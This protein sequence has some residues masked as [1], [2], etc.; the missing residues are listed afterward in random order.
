MY[1]QLYDNLDTILSEKQHG[2]RKGFSLVNS[3]LSKTE[4]FRE[5]VDQVGA[6]GSL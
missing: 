2:L 1:N 4:K 6:Y 3:F 5:S